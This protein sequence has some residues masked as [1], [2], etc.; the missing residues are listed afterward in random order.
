MI[1]VALLALACGGPL[2]GSARLERARHA[3][4]CARVPHA[5]RDA[6]GRDEPAPGVISAGLPDEVRRVALAARLDDE[7]LADRDYL[8]ERVM[9][10]QAEI[11]ATSAELSCLDDQLESL[12]DELDDRE[13]DYEL[14]FTVSSVALGAL[15]ALAAGVLD[16]VTTDS[17]APAIT[18]IVGGVGSATLGIAAFLP[19]TETVELVHERNLLSAIRE[20]AARAEGTFPR[21]VATLLDSPR[22]SGESPRARIQAGWRETFEGVAPATTEVFFGRGGRYNLAMLQAREL[23]I[24]EIET[25]IE[26]AR[27]DLELLLRYLYQSR[28]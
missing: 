27:Q 3:S 7:R 1:G 15:A 20:G 23:A 22:A 21:F 12:H 17:P 2:A 18:G 6:R 4:E 9:L 25:E 11:D 24:E 5:V 26:L 14:I 8:I 28:R 19:P 16:L 10:L 13:R